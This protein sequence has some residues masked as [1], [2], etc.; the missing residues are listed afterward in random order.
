MMIA[1]DNAMVA[2]RPVRW[3]MGRV[4]TLATAL[5][6]TGVVGTFLLFW[7]ADTQLGLSREMIQTLIFL[8]LLVAGHMTL[9]VTRSQRWF[10]SRPWPSLKLLLTTEATQVL[11][12]LVAVYGVFVTPIGWGYAL[13]VWGY[14]AVWMLIES[15]VAVYVRHELD[16]G[17]ER[18]RRHIARMER[19][20]G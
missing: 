20:L 15:A 10:W 17:A 13:A 6:A 5:G 7:Y 3:K 16:L 14:A 9:Y 4:L 18:H 11:G 19:R 12:T 2:E 8:K 1:Y